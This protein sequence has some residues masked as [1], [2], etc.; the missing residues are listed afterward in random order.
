MKKK[1]YGFIAVLLIVAVMMFTGERIYS[2]EE[3]SLFPD[4]SENQIL[5]WSEYG[6]LST[7][8]KNVTVESGLFFDKN[9]KKLTSIDTERKLISINPQG[10]VTVLDDVFDYRHTNIPIELW[11][12]PKGGIYFIHTS[13]DRKKNPESNRKYVYYLSP[14]RKILIRVADD[15]S[16]P[17]SII[18]SPDG[19]LLYIVDSGDNNMY[20][21][22][23]NADGQLTNKRLYDPVIGDGS[24][25]N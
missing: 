4:P 3:N 6:N 21:F 19:T 2:A 12:N 23:I 20:F 16:T 10:K 5:K 13:L 22:D 9:G 25:D 1:W 18:G 14:D 11:I 24:G 15:L 17:D 8:L 7:I